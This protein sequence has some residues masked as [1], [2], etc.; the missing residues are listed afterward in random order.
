M[1]RPGELFGL[2]SRYPEEWFQKEKGKILGEGAF[3][4]VWGFSTPE[5]ELAVKESSFHDQQL[6]TDPYLLRE[7]SFMYRLKHP[8]IL[9][10][11]DI[12]FSHKTMSLVFPMGSGNLRDYMNENHKKLS[13]DPILVKSLMLQIMS[14][15]E[16]L[17]F[18]D[19]LHGDIKPENVIMQPRTRTNENY[20][21]QIWISDF[22]IATVGGCQ[23]R[24]KS[25]F[26]TFAYQAPELKAGIEYGGPAD[27]YAI[28]VIFYEF[29]THKIYTPDQSIEFQD[30]KITELLRSMLAV[31]PTKRSKLRTLID[32]PWFRE[33]KTFLQLKVRDQKRKYENCYDLLI[34]TEA[35]L[36]SENSKNYSPRKIYDHFFELLFRLKISDRVVSVILAMFETVMPENDRLLYF[37]AVLSLVTQVLDTDNEDLEKSI[38]TWIG[39]KEKIVNIKRLILRSRMDDYR[40]GLDYFMATSYD[41]VETHLFDYVNP[42]TASAARTLLQVSYYTKLAQFHSPHQIAKLCIFLGRAYSGEKYKP[43]KTDQDDLKFKI[44]IFL[45]Q[46]DL[47]EL[48]PNLDSLR[49]CQRGEIGIWQIVHLAMKNVDYFFEE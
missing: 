15:I 13:Q 39:R 30:P 14:A 48:L 44:M 4:R 28:G 7:A 31:D 20:L 19:I 16:Y 38:Y 5:G 17:H 1:E 47:T 43:I 34:S 24:E 42:I 18:N 35:K 12:F 11:K 29:L 41:F 27:M 23:R 32:D 8:N 2:L 40:P 49:R 9:P 25:N 10:L 22:G 46:Q 3:G 37:Q 6:G 45:F 33:G 36:P 21:P 26:F